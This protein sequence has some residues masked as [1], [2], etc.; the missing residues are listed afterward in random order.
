[1]QNG[2]LPGGGGEAMTGRV[3]RTGSAAAPLLPS[4]P[5]SPHR[6]LPRPLRTQK[7]SPAPAQPCRLSG[8]FK[9]TL[10]ALSA[11]RAVPAKEELWQRTLG[12]LWG[13]PGWMSE[14]QPTGRGA[15]KGGGI[16]KR[17]LPS[18]LPTHSPRSPPRSPPRHS[19]GLNLM[20]SPLDGSNTKNRLFMHHTKHTQK[21]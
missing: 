16:S 9:R 4:S 18:V 10:L 3:S 21:G 11:H 2:H 12:L 20:T 8:G 6:P 1:M 15:E 19:R 17:L 14:H 5:A 7:A 13:S